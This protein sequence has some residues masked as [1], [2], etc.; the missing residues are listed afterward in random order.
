MPAD[1]L[2][3]SQADKAAFIE[4]SAFPA[5]SRVVSLLLIALLLPTRHQ[6]ITHG[7]FLGVDARHA[8][9]TALAEN[10]QGRALPRK[11]H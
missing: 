6:R 1:K 7:R 3:S 8:I 5:V 10:G 9:L 11:V 2:T 4:M